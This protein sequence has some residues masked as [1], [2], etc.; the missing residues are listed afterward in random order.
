MADVTGALPGAVAKHDV[1]MRTLL[2]GYPGVMA[3]LEAAEPVLDIADLFGGAARV[4]ATTTAGLDLLVLDAPHLY[5]RPGNIYSQPR[6]LGIGRTMPSASGG[7]PASPPIS[8][9][10]PSPAGCPDM[11]CI[12]TTGKPASPP[13]ICITPARTR[14]RTVMTIHNLAFTGQVPLALRGMLGLPEGSLTPDGVEFYQS[15]SAT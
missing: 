5:D 15:P 12:A 10:A 3:A 1:E 13:P 6:W 4:L 8:A 14:P 11:R 7:S 9:W 2:P